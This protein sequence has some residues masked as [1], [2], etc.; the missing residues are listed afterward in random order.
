MDGWE[1]KCGNRCVRFRV[2]EGWHGTGSGY[3]RKIWESLYVNKKIEPPTKSGSNSPD[4]RPGDDGSLL[5]CS[6]FHLKKTKRDFDLCACGDL[7]T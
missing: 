5:G 4:T 1:M 6:K 3:S 2:P 7:S